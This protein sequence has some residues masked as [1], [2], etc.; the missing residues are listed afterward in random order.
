MYKLFHILVLFCDWLNCCT[1]W[2]TILAWSVCGDPG[3]E[4]RVLY[5]PETE[6]DCSGSESDNVPDV[7]VS[8][9]KERK[10]KKESWEYRIIRRKKM[11]NITIS[12]FFCAEMIV[13]PIYICNLSWR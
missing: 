10:R 12:E 1:A 6:L 2:A 9:K 11:N 7:E 5:I 8:I 3:P 4:R 13:I